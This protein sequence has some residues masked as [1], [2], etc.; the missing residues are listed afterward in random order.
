MRT[1]AHFSFWNNFFIIFLIFLMLRMCI[2]INRSGVFVYLSKFVNC[3]EVFIIILGVCT[4]LFSVFHVITSSFYINQF[5][6]SGLDSFFNFY[7]IMYY[8]YVSKNIL[9]ILFGFVVIRLLMS[10][11]FGRKY[12]DYYY[13]FLLSLPWIVWLT[14]L[15]ILYFAI[16]WRFVGYLSS[17]FIFPYYNTI[18][19]HPNYFRDSSYNKPI[20]YVVILYIMCALCLVLNAVFIASFVYYYRVAKAY[21]LLDTDTFNYIEFLKDEYKSF[22]R[23]N[24]KEE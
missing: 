10:F 8:A 13:T 16:M 5:R 21:K 24:K 20:G 15:F 12:I 19:V 2:L 22:R 7:K 3:F 9:S 23:R 18:I 14:M 17:N 6:S 11:K 1:D 4:V